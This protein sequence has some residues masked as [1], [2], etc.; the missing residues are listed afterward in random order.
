MD[1]PTP[2][3]A[4]E[5]MA[6]GCQVCMSKSLTMPWLTNRIAMHHSVHA[7]IGEDNVA[8]THPTKTS[9]DV[10]SGANFAEVVRI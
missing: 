9:V 3:E 10:G 2:Q 6:L 5:A 1:N 7:K 8:R 4:V